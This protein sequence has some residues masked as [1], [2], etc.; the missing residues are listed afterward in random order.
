MGRLEALDPADLKVTVRR[1]S[2]DRWAVR[3]DHLPTGVHAE[4]DPAGSALRAREQ[5]MERLLGRLM[6]VWEEDGRGQD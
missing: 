5:A 3:I 2:G 1:V 6:L 4:S